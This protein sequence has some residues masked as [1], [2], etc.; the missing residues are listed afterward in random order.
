LKSATADLE[1]IISD[2]LNLKSQ[3]ALSETRCEMAER[4]RDFF[5]GKLRDIEILLTLK[6]QYGG[7]E[8]IIKIIEKV[9]QARDD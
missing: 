6:D 3:L 2:N 4:E 8:P 5:F 7:A 9:L 1:H